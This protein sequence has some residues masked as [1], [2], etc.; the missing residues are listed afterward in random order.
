M[1]VLKTFPMIGGSKTVFCEDNSGNNVVF[2]CFFDKGKVST[3]TELRNG[4]M[5]VMPRDSA[6]QAILA[7]LEV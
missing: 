7:S 2:S 1:R 5:T 3:V 6:P 4:G